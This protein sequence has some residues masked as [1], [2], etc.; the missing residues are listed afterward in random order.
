VEYKLIDN[1]LPEEDFLFIKNMFLSSEFPW[2]LNGSIVDNVKILNEKST[3]SFQFTHTFFDN[4]S[5][6][7]EW[8][9]NLAPIIDKINP[10][11][12]L[13]IKANLGPRH[14]VVEEQGYH[15]D[16]SFNCTTAILYLTANDGYTIFE[17]GTKIESVENRFVEFNSELKH[18][19]TSH[20]DSRVRVV[21]NMNYFKDGGR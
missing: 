10:K 20:T 4:W 19:G 6:K 9:T 1:F 12:W 21:L 14:D 11:A 5:F 8:A 3:D 2:F 15:T 18:S 13:R 16:Y 7:S 17:D